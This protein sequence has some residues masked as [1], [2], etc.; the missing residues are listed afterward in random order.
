MNYDPVEV[1]IDQLI[2]KFRLREWQYDIEECVE[3]IAEALK[4]IG[5]QKIYVDDSAILTVNGM[6]APLPKGCQHVKGIDP[7]STP[8][9]EQG[10][11]IQ[12]DVPDG[13]QF[14]LD[15]Q[16]MPLDARGYPL[17][18]DHPSVRAAVMWFLVNTLVLQG[19]IKHVGLQYA[20]TE[21]HWRCKS[22]RAYLNT[23][24]VQT[25]NKV[26]NDFTRLNPT[27]D[28]HLKNYQELGQ[29][30]T[31]DRERSKDQFVTR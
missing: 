26:F 7:A 14:K 5:A 30:N 11:F 16:S 27:K 19:G 3:D 28:A 20:D 8:Y 31:L 2:R 18:P 15:Y 22:A 29:A 21:W 12:M 25:A 10:P 9:K 1:V 6:L 17:M 23:W 13:T 4:F 24:D